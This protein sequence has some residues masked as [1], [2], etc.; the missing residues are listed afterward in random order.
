MISRPFTKYTIC[1]K[2]FSPMDINHSWQKKVFDFQKRNGKVDGGEMEGEDGGE[3]RQD[4]KT[5]K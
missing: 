1:V 5:K 3:T 2:N 4:N